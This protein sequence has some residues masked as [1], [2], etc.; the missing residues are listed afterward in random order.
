MICNQLLAEIAA[1]VGFFGRFNHDVC[2]QLF[3][4]NL[5]MVFD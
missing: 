4:G 5:W 3:E 2:I 1:E